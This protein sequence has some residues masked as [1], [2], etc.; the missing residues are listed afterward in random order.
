MDLQG[1]RRFTRFRI[2]NLSENGRDC[3]KALRPHPR[4]RWRGM[5]R[6]WCQGTAEG[7]ELGT[8]IT[9]GLPRSEAKTVWL[10]FFVAVAS[11]P[12]PGPRRHKAA[13]A[14]APH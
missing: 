8:I 7:E 5:A 6:R 13:T 10:P 12:A 3:R 14:R 9:L 4:A 2:P 1:P 11:R